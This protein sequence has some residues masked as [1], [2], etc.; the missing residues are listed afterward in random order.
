MKRVFPKGQAPCTMKEERQG[1]IWNMFG[2]AKNVQTEIDVKLIETNPEQP[3]KV[4]ER[5]ELEEL[6]SSILE[7]GVIQP[8]VVK[9]GL[10]GQYFLIAGE[11]RLRAATMAGLEKIPAIIRN[12]D[13]KE[14]ALIALVENVQRENLS[15]IEEAVA[16]KRLMEDYG[17]TQGEISRRVGKQQ[18]TISNKIRLLILPEDLQR[19][20]AE[21]Q[22]SER[23]ARALLKLP[24]NEVRKQILEKIIAHNLNVKQSDK[25][26]EDF[27]SKTEKEKTRA[28]RLRYINYRIYLNTLKK[29]FE[30]IN[31]EDKNAE[32]YQEDKGEYVEVR[33]RIPKKAG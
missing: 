4:F 23:H 14:V 13:E 6:S 11:R 24:D 8:I 10:E 20:L 26:I 28:D 29:A 12:A 33:I 27:L 21:H 16:Y 3:R 30:S 7:F 1:G 32:Y 9:K 15:Y 22:L 17:L 5:Q 19:T 25:L 31:K 2:R 18:S